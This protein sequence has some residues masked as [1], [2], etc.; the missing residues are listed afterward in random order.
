MKVSTYVNQIFSYIIGKGRSSESTSRS[1]RLCNTVSITLRVFLAA[2]SRN[3][4]PT[5]RHI[6]VLTNIKWPPTY[7]LF[8]NFKTMSPPFW[9][10]LLVKGFAKNVFVISP[11]MIVGEATT[12]QF[13]QTQYYSSTIAFPTPKTRRDRWTGI[14][15]L[16]QQIENQFL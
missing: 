3:T 11:R 15:Q 16:R 5:Y 7:Y 12:T 14:P 9:T 10:L 1:W 13:T 6:S 2:W 8:I 4:R